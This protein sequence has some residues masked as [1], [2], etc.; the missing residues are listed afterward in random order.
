MIFIDGRQ[1]W[2]KKTHGGLC[3][4]SVPSAGLYPAM[5]LVSFCE[6]DI[7]PFIF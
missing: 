1:M 7:S 6:D 3:L 5:F 4:G 2:I